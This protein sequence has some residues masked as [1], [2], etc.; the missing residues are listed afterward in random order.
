M[1]EPRRLLDEA[2]GLDRA[3]LES[4][5]EDEPAAERRQRLLASFGGTS[6]AALTSAGSAKRLAALK[7]T[8]WKIVVG[9]AVTVGVGIGALGLRDRASTSHARP[10]ASSLAPSVDPA[11]APT[12]AESS[13]V[14]ELAVVTPSALPDATLPTRGRSPRANPASI[15]REIALIDRARSALAAGAAQRALAVLREYDVAC[16]DGAMSLEA[17]VLRIE[18]IAASGDQAGAADRASTFLTKHPRTAYDGR[19][20]AHLANP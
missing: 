15:G 6:L 19:V 17:E 4:A 14:G 3:V 5:V 12:A 16:P 1:M 8:A 18:A 7:L 13:P 20:R 2:S 11:A 10:T 9:V